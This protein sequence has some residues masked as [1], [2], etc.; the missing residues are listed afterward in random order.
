MVL[1]LTIGELTAYI[2]NI[3]LRWIIVIIIAVYSL[4]LITLWAIRRMSLPDGYGILKEKRRILKTSIYLFIFFSIGAINMA[5]FKTKFNTLDDLPSGSYISIS[6][7][8]IEVSQDNYGYVIVIKVDGILYEVHIDS[9]PYEI[10]AGNIVTI[11]G[12]VDFMGVARNPGNFSEYDYLHSKGFG[13][14]IKADS[15]VIENNSVDEI[16]IFSGNMRNILEKCIDEICDKKSAGLLKAMILGDKSHTD[17]D[18]KELYTKSGIAHL[19]AISGLHI[20][21]IGMSLFNILRKKF[22]YY[23][24]GIISGTAMIF[25]CVMT[26]GSVSTKRAVIMFAITLVGKITGYAYDIISSA[27]LAAIILLLSNPYY[28]FNTAFI[29]SFMA[30]VAIGV[31]FPTIKSEFDISEFVI[32][33]IHLFS[34]SRNEKIQK[35][36]IGFFESLL[37][38]VVL[39]ITSIPIVAYMYF[40]IP[41]FGVLLNIIVIPLMSLI[42]GCGLC[43]MCLTTI[44]I[45]MGKFIVGTS[46]GILKIYEELCNF[47]SKLPYSTVITGRPSSSSIVI[48]YIFLTMVCILCIINREGRGQ[49]DGDIKCN[50]DNNKS[51]FADKKKNIAGKMPKIIR[52]LI[53]SFVF[54]MMFVIFGERSNDFVISVID[55]GQG[56]CIVVNM[57]RG[58]I[59]MIDCGST[60]IK[61]VA[62]KKV[63]PCM[64]ALGYSAIDI[65]IV[66]H[67]DADHISGIIEIIENGYFDIGMIILPKLSYEDGVCEGLKNLCKNSNIPVREGYFGNE[68]K[69]GEVTM[70]CL[71]PNPQHFCENV[72]PDINAY[73]QVWFLK[74][75]NFTALFTG[76]IGEKQEEILIQ[77]LQHLNIDIGGEIDLLKVAHHGSRNSTTKGFL[78][79]FSPRYAVIS[80]GVGNSYGHP[81]MDLL[82]RLQPVAGK[83]HITSKDMYFELVY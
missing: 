69:I 53:V 34:N 62:N 73:S 57:P 25:F 28:L 45:P 29:M 6:E 40:E 38:S 65:A 13:L 63:V 50:A 78:Q 70:T 35:L 54:V 49:N 74:Y 39:N 80:C 11:K 8:I 55:V 5:Y 68:I 36:L 26:G 12:V 46:V 48:Y 19:L 1:A 23:T 52:I 18:I 4:F 16:K 51:S 77:D 31:V 42:L 10:S 14:K 76:D 79:L 64:K 58:D 9:L 43:A 33:R 67:A 66:T 32:N 75:K 20:S 37:L 61:N 72:Y 21:I 7:E 30:I 83:I 71:S 17:K 56:D 24:S 3:P 41:P 47:V 81:H 22:S 27:S 59:V 15:I 44:S 2:I 82:E 60:D